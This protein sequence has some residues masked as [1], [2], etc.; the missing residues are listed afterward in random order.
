M[1]RGQRASCARLT[2]SI[3][4]RSAK[5]AQNSQTRIP[6]S[7]R[8]WRGFPA[9]RCRRRLGVNRGRKRD[10]SVSALHGRRSHRDGRRT[11]APH[12]LRRG[13]G[14]QA[15]R[16]VRMVVEASGTVVGVAG[17]AV[18][19]GVCS[20]AMRSK[21]AGDCKQCVSSCFSA[22]PCCT[23]APQPHARRSRARSPKTGRAGWWPISGASSRLQG[24]KTRVQA[25]GC[26][27]LHPHGQSNR[28][29]QRPTGV[30]VPLAAPWERLGEAGRGGAVRVRRLSPRGCALCHRP[31]ALRGCASWG[32]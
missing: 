17:V 6:G 15:S 7:Q 19:A 4:S 5:S 26:G 11:P 1:N 25:A 2:A 3:S 12:W 30:A 32:L 24:S 31:R 8:V 22:S 23:E 13:R 9:G 18:G 10:Y 27:S 14:G 21:R 20:G 16:S 28:A 29:A